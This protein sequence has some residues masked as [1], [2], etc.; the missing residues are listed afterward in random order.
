MIIII[1]LSKFKN[2]YFVVENNLRRYSTEFILI[3]FL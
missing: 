2:L 3:Y 1:F